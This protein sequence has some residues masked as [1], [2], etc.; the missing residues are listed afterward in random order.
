MKNNVI[1]I[2]IIALIIGLGAGF[3]GG[4]QYQSSKQ[5][6]VASQYG[7]GQ[8]GN[9]QYGP[10]GMVRNGN[11]Q[12][13]NRNGGGV[14]QIISM[15]AN[16]ITVKLANGS[17]RIILLSDSTSIE[18]TT[19]ASRTDL[20]VGDNVLVIGQANSDGSVTAKNIQINPLQRN[21]SGTP[22][23]NTSR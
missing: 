4:M 10:G 16:S 13:R 3:F 11:G 9:G 19:S 22:T 2:G 7:S 8:F 20:K 12:A 18:Q 6:T 15:D 21:P 1:L 17:T 5:T 14:G 23:G